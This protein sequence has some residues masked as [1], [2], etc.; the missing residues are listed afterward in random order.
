MLL[1]YHCMFC[2]TQQINK[3]GSQND[4]GHEKSYARRRITTNATLGAFF[5][6]YR[7]IAFHVSVRLK[8]WAFIQRNQ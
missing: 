5:Q 4:V 3:V 2:S 7:T 8:V 6:S 1:S